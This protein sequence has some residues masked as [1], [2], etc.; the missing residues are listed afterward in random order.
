LEALRKAAKVIL[1]YAHAELA[2]PVKNGAPVKLEESRKG[3]DAE[4]L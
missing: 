2:L 3:G 4:D 1:G